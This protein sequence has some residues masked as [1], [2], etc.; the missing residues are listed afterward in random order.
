MEKQIFILIQKNTKTLNISDEQTLA[1]TDE[2]DLNKLQV[3][4]LRDIAKEKGLKGVSK[5]KKKELISLLTQ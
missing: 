3:T 4:Q 1:E 2:D 5:M